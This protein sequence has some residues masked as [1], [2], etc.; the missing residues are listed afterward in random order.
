MW[1]QTR[2]ADDNTQC[3]YQDAC[4]R[5]FEGLA[6]TQSFLSLATGNTSPPRQAD[7][8]CLL[9]QPALG[10]W[11]TDQLWAEHSWRLPSGWKKH[12]GKLIGQRGIPTQRFH[13]RTIDVINLA[14]TTPTRE[15]VTMITCISFRNTHKTNSLSTSWQVLLCVQCDNEMMILSTIEGW[16]QLISNCIALETTTTPPLQQPPPLQKPPSPPFEKLC[17]CNVRLLLMIGTWWACD[18]TALRACIII[19]MIRYTMSTL[20]Q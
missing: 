2:G 11:S 13:L 18:R 17:E 7:S 16:A 9:Y 3:E 6:S 20:I 4:L 14:N 19:F 10:N 15:K 8:Q 5:A 1:H 12:D